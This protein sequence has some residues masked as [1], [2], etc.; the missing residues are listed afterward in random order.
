[1]RLLRE[2]CN[3][4]ET[5]VLNSCRAQNG[6]CTIDM[7]AAMHASGSF[8]FVINERLRPKADAIEPC[9]NPSSCFFLSN[10]LGVRLKGNFLQRT[11]KRRAQRL[12]HL[13][14]ETGLEQ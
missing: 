6:H 7:L 1:M 2:T 10:G 8:Q 13:A 11:R 3:K 14:K 5:N 12:H 9:G 4:V